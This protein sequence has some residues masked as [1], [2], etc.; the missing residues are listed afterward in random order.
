MLHPLTEKR[1]PVAGRP[2]RSAFCV[3]VKINS[4]ANDLSLV[5][6]DFGSTLKSAAA[7]KITI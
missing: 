3:T 6:Q 7:A 4:K 1:L 2:G 5:T